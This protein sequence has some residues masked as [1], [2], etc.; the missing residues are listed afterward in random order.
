MKVLVII[1][2]YNEQDSILKTVNKLIEDAP[3]VDYIVIN[4]CSLDNT[5]DILQTNHINHVAL[6]VNLGIGGAVQC[7][8][9]YALENNYDIAIQL[10]GDG[11][12]DSTYLKSLISPIEN[13]EADIAIGSRFINHEGFQSSGIRRLGIRFLNQMIYLATGY[14]A[15]DCTSGFRAVNK[16]YIEKYAIHYPMDYPEP[17]AIVY[18]S[19]HGAK[20]LDVPVIMKERNGGVSSIRPIHSGYYM[21]K[22]SLAILL[23]KI[24]NLNVKKKSC[25]D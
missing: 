20:I 22:V 7:G 23:C 2:A 9:R 12:H 21:I 11:Q 6:P 15:T 17:E 1:P 19:L 18:A 4:D 25:T 5:L 3:W 24:M 13:G 8:Y 16:K 10:D 14:K